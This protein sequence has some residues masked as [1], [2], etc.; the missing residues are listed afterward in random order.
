MICHKAVASIHRRST[1]ECFVL[2]LLWNAWP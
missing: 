2:Y 1:P